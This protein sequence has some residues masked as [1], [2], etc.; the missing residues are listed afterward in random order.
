[1]VPW[2]GWAVSFL[3]LVREG[4]I[5]PRGIVGGRVACGLGTGRDREKAGWGGGCSGWRTAC[6]T[7]RSWRGTVDWLSSS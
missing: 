7:R 3:F 6:S 2:L 1:M 4:I 5:E